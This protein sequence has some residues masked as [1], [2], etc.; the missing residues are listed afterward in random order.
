M[1]FGIAA[2]VDE[3]G[4]TSSLYVPG[5]IVVYK[6]TNEAWDII[7]KFAYDPGQAE[8]IRQMREC[9]TPMIHRIRETSQIFVGLAVDGLP[10]FELEQAGFG[11][12]EFE[13]N[14]AEFLDYIQEQEEFP[15]E[16]EKSNLVTVP[17]P[18][19][20]RPGEFFISIKELQ[21]NAVGLNSR[22]VL[23]PFLHSNAYQVLEVRCKHIP[24]WL[25][26]ELGGEKFLHTQEVLGEH[27]VRLVI[28]KNGQF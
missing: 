12:W 27:D 14:P 7:D 5:Y 13:G 6:K 20:V 17:S 9:I 25:S 18:K 21:G 4:R 3:Q 22:Q 28:Q 19:E 11:I 15:P 8:N 24:P 2:A 16:E 1:S 10:G 23:E 26:A